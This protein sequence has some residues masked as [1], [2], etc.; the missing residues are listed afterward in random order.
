MQHHTHYSRHRARGSNVLPLE[1]VPRHSPSAQDLLQIANGL[2]AQRRP[3]AKEVYDRVIELDPTC[4]E[5]YC[6]RGL[7]LGR[8]GQPE[9][10]LTDFNRAI[11]LD[12]G[13]ATAYY[14]RG[15]AYGNLGRTGEEIED[16]YPGDRVVSRTHRRLSEPGLCVR[17]A[18][19]L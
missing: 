16:L 8:L 5:A 7:V 15:C 17:Q 6:N 14:G 9:R 12:P 2:L 4:V 10:A 18:S 13:Q 1:E 19:A 11:E 3:E